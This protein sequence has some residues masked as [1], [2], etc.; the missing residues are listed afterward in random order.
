MIKDLAKAV[1]EQEQQKRARRKNEATERETHNQPDA[2]EAGPTQDSSK[3][4]K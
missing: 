1:M 4:E 2:V 3:S